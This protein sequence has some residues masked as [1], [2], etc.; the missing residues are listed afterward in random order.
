MSRKKNRFLFFALIILLV[1]FVFLSPAKEIIRKPAVAGY[2]YPSSS[3]EL[4]NTIQ[5]LIINAE[6]P[7]YKGDVRAMILPHAGYRYSGRVAADALKYLPDAKTVIILAPSHHAGFQGASIPDVTHYE[8]PLGQ[9]KLSSK[10]KKLLQEDFI[11]N[12]ETA[13]DKEHSIE[14][15]LPL[16]Q[17]KLDDFEIVPVLVGQTDPEM[18]ATAIDKII[19]ENTLIIASS[20]LSHYYTHKRA[21]ELDNICIN[22][23][24]NLSSLDLM[25]C[26]ACGK[27]PIKSL[28]EIAKKQKWKSHLIKAENS[29]DITG[30]KKRVVGYASFI[31]TKGGITK[32]E[33]KKLFQLA[34]STIESHIKGESIELEQY[35]KFSKVQG[36]FV[37][38]KKNNI[39]RGCIGDILPQRPLYECIHSNAVNAAV[40]DLRFEPLKEHELEQIEIEIS[41]LSV[42]QELKFN[43]PD[44]L[45]KKLRPGVDGVVIKYRGRTS[46]YLPQVWEQLPEKENFLKHLC[47][48][49]TS[50][51]DCWKRENVEILTYQA[52][53]F[54]E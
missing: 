39:L 5:Q 26:E 13:H 42:P 41:V 49:Q 14:V 22:A 31:L 50:P 37:T 54:E 40:N 34:S 21:K 35:N 38:I 33:Q 43:N 32:P 8:T 6:N 4:T 28:I 9:V 20:D 17:Y 23:I 45:L 15:Q 19:D 44:E 2:F 12:H 7:D 10:T 30:E 48:K 16:L 24:L 11:I 18:L 36:C 52:F 51:P 27:I 47:E 1:L 3:Q 25:Y 29:G 46:T 53:V